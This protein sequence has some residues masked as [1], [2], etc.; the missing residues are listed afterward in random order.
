MNEQMLKRIIKEEIKK[1]LNEDDSATQS[2]TNLNVGSDATPAQRQAA[3]EWQK[4]YSQYTNAN[5]ASSIESA[6]NA[7]NVGNQRKAIQELILAIRNML[8]RR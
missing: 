5:A 1:L 8:Y 7:L 6:Q 4:K 3:E 2:A